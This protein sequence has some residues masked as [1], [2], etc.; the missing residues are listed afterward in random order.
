MENQFNNPARIA[1][2]AARVSKNRLQVC[3]WHDSNKG[4][5]MCN[6]RVY[7]ASILVIA[8]VVALRRALLPPAEC[9]EVYLVWQVAFKSNLASLRIV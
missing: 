6:C 1:V 3:E 4:V 8:V 9:G 2:V 5:L 7:H